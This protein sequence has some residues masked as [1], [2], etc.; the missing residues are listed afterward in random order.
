MKRRLLDFSGTAAAYPLSQGANVCAR[1]NP[2]DT[3]QRQ[4]RSL[5]PRCFESR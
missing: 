1:L 5:W 4:R 3:V 2:H